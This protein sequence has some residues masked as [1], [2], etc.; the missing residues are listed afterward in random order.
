[1]HQFD[2]L[3]QRDYRAL[4]QRHSAAQTSLTL[5]AG[6]LFGTIK[7]S[8]HLRKLPGWF[9]GLSSCSQRTLLLSLLEYITSSQSAFLP[10]R[11]FYTKHDVDVDI[12]F[13]TSTHSEGVITMNETIGFIGLG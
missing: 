8:T 12:M 11:F 9:H 3:C 5:R 2:H 13:G 4:R 10:L 6:R 7:P 1:M